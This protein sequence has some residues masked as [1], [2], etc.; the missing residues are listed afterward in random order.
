M[1]KM[2]TTCSSLNE[3]YLGG[4]LNPWLLLVLLLFYFGGASPDNS[5]AII[6]FPLDW[7]DWA[8]SRQLVLTLTCSWALRAQIF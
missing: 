1:W 8:A 5:T 4:N 2:V 6:S 7:E 3:Y